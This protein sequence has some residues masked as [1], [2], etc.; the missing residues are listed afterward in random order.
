[1]SVSKIQQQYTILKLTLLVNMSQRDRCGLLVGANE[2]LTRVLS[3]FRK[4]P[5]SNKSPCGQD[6]GSLEEIY[7]TCWK[8]KSVKKI[9]QMYII[10]NFI[11]A[12][13]SFWCIYE[14]RH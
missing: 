2:E 7:S 12:K 8:P 13:G 14:A 9:Q 3:N 10:F 6:K 4:K 5:P 11:D 1:M